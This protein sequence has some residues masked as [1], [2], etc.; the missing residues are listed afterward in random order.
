MDTKKQKQLVEYY[1]M[2][3]NNIL[4][5][6]ILS[7]KCKKIEEHIK[8]L[9]AVSYL[10]GPALRRSN[11][12]TE[13]FN[14]FERYEIVKE[15]S[16]FN[17]FLILILSD[18]RFDIPMKNEILKKA[19]KIYLENEEEFSNKL[20]ENHF[21][22]KVMNLLLKKLEN[23]SKYDGIRNTSL[24]KMFCKIIEY[25]VLNDD[26]SL[27]FDK[28]YLKPLYEEDGVFRLELLNRSIALSCPVIQL[29]KVLLIC[30]Y[31]NNDI[32]PDI[33]YAVDI[34]KWFVKYYERMRMG[35]ILRER[36]DSTDSDHSYDTYTDE[37]MEMF[38]TK[39]NNLIKDVCDT[40]RNVAFQRRRHLMMIHS[41]S[42][43]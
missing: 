7:Y 33:T 24:I 10:H 14:P 4:Q 5:I 13:S 6:D 17:E 9:T 43:L 19:K 1:I 31:I 30:I 34:K 29:W 40:I 18:E 21:S 25:N 35:Y 16:K 28:I 2:Y 39:T 22:E 15:F 41:R 26:K 42:Y 36:A 23:E 3:M 12:M 38:S 11:A 20:I 27:C 32:D 37:E 8:I